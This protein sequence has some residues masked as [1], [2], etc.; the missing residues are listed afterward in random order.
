MINIDFDL[1]KKLNRNAS[2]REL[3]E[4]IG[5]TD[6]EYNYW[7]QAF[8]ANVVQSLDSAYNEYNFICDFRCK[9]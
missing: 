8:E 2:E 9:S 3:I 6:D 1:E 7:K 5:I 4:F